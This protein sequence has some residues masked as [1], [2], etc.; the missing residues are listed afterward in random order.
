MSWFSSAVSIDDQVQRAT[1]ESLPTGEQDFVLN[2][3]ICDLIRSK[4]VQPKDAMR[5]LKRRLLHKNPNVQIATLHLVDFCIKNGGSHFLVEIA[6]RE[7]IDTVLLVLK[8]LSNSTPVNLDVQNLI[9][10]CIQN[11]ANA[12]EG[13]IQLA[14]VGQVYKQLK[15]EGFH[16]PYYATKISSSFIDS[17]AP[18]EWVDSDTC[19]KSGTPFTFVNRKHHCRNCGGVYI[20][21]YCNNYTQLPHF[22]INQAVRV[23]DDCFAKLKYGGHKKTSSKSHPGTVPYSP[24]GDSAPP[25]I[26]DEM[27]ADLK[28]ALQLSLEESKGFSPSYS[29]PAP[30]YS[31]PTP[32][33]ASVAPKSDAPRTG[34]EDDE[35][36]KAAIAASL[37]D[38]QGPASASP[39]GDLYSSNNI[40][41][42][43]PAQRP[44]WELTQ[45]E[46]DNINMYATLVEKLKTAPPGAILREGKIQDLNESITSLRP[47]VARTLADVVTKYDKL[48]DMNAKLTTAIRFYD[49]L[50]EDRLS[51]AYNRHSISE[52]PPAFH[53]QQ[54]PP[55]QQYGQYPPSVQSQSTG[56]TPLSPQHTYSV[57]FSPSMTPSAPSYPPQAP[58][59]QPFSG[60]A[61]QPQDPS[62]PQGYRQSSP[63][64]QY[65]APPPELSPQVQNQQP[66]MPEQTY[67]QPPQQYSQP[68]QYQEPLQT[69]SLNTNRGPPKD[70]PALIDL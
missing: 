23:C 60:G 35:D 27:D 58:P 42:T 57:P 18:P 25:I 37:R 34:E 1:S 66:Q 13:Q 31:A 28:R 69:S 39:S 43:D 38:M 53:S 30:A 22:G 24:S 59:S 70:E 3:E 2:L 6:S 55:Y 56:Q 4:T 33:N 11:W 36:L 21:Q 64:H 41:S 20:Q 19:M 62:G 50:L 14:Y 52:H 10:E 8:P 29:A 68:A 48:V 12:F 49:S 44:S 40:P 45:I 63:V 5:S 15:D 65:N 9:L 7:F 54:Q 17:S 61:P 26:E 67:Y 46:S 51:Y 32:H 16:F 47:K